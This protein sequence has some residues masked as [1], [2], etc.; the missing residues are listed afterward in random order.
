MLIW[1]QP[2]LLTPKKSSLS[3][4]VSNSDPSHLSA[5]DVFP[6]FHFAFFSFCREQRQGEKNSVFSFSSRISRYQIL[7]SVEGERK[8]WK[9]VRL[10]FSIF[11]LSMNVNGLHLWGW[12]GKFKSWKVQT[13]RDKTF[14]ISLFV[15]ASE[16]HSGEL[17]FL[18]SGKNPLSRGE[19]ARE[20]DFIHKNI[21]SN[22]AQVSAVRSKGRVRVVWAAAKSWEDE[23][24]VRVKKKKT[25]SYLRR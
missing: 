8:L 2:P 14:S 7:N 10:L 3:F 25:K 5:F 20:D 23:N 13:T 1:F 16:R 6:I 9:F 15:V 18:V 4:I 22:L 11:L 21:Y 19:K 12:E 17:F 24:C